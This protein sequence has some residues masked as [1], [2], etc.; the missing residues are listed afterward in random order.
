MGTGALVMFVVGA[1]LLWGG[2]ALAIA[3]YVV[4]A[5]REVRRTGGPGA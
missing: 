2:L 1:L 5:R 3:N 4:S